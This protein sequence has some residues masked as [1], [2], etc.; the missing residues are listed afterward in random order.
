MPGTGVTLPEK[1]AINSGFTN[2][3][4]PIITIYKAP[5]VQGTAP[6][7]VICPGGGYEH[8]AYSKEGVEIV[9]WLNTL[10]ITG[11]VL[12]YRVPKNREG[13][14]QDIQRAVRLVRSN[15]TN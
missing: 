11:V 15:A 4:N 1:G 12:K 7:I 3:S 13:A 9:Q 6:A 5:G 10:G 8:L 2:V 14:A